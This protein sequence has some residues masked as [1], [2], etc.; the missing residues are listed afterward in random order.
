MIYDIGSLNYYTKALMRQV[1][2]FTSFKRQAVS[3][4]YTA[5]FF[6]IANREIFNLALKTALM[7]NPI[8]IKFII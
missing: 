6:N 1:H 8:L 4:G 7:S 5:T 2:K 3:L